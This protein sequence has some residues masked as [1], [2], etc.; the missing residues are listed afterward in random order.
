MA[1][2]SSSE[3]FNFAAGPSAL[4]AEVLA[5]VRDELLTRA[6]SPTPLEQPFSGSAFRA[7][8]ER[9]EAGLITLLG[10]PSNYHVLFLAGG[11][12][13]QFGLLPLNLRGPARR[14]A[15]VDSG[16]WAGRA[17]S[18]A[19]RYGEVVVAARSASAE[20]GVNLP[21]FDRWDIPEDAAYCHYTANETA[22]GA[23]FPAPDA[24][25]ADNGVP[26][27]C[28]MT[29]SFLI[30]PLDV[31]R[32]GLIYA[33][34]QKNLGPAGMT[35]LLV[36]EDLLGRAAPETPDVFNYAL[37]AEAHSC[38]NTPPTFAVGLTALMFDWITERGGLASMAAANA[39]KSA[40]VYGAIAESDGFYRCP[41]APVWRSTVNV[42]FT[43]A[44]GALTETFLAEAEAAG[45]LNLRGHPRVGGVRASLYNALPETAAVALAGFMREFVRRHG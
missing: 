35:V 38:R 9:A 27:V 45:L 26:L 22:D 16:Y 41:V 34:A 33:G 14:F 30:A 20:H 21:A 17:I 5:R 2:S 23:A 31:R 29:S 13:T 6:G 19:Q 24:S 44:D 40:Y 39:T 18:E 10:L 12:M 4:P 1:D 7:L 11:A 15:Y 37:Q 8:R 28:D 36:R 42:C 3:P 25:L 43:L 32:F